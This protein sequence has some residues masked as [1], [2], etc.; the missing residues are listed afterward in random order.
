MT[1]TE[2][3]IVSAVKMLER[4]ISNDE[5]Y[6]LLREGWKSLRNNP[7]QLKEITDYA[8]YGRGLFAL[9]T[10]KTI[11]DLDDRQQLASLSYLYLSKAII[12]NPENADAQGFRV[13]LMFFCDGPLRY[14]ISSVV[15]KDKD[16]WERNMHPFAARDAL[17][18]ME[19][20]AIYKNDVLFPTIIQNSWLSGKYSELC[21]KV[22]SGFFGSDIS[23]DSI[24]EEGDL[25]HKNILEYIENKVLLEEDV[26]F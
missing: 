15:N 14:T 8:R 9:L 18:K 26:V 1:E 3:Y 10:Y 23:A 6:L 5:T 25:L 12:K 24:K 22:N 17:Y 20:A 21:D 7:S 19:F 11:T 4:R 2:N 13:I 16:L